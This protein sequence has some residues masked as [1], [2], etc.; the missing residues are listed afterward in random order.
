MW[1]KQTA[2][3]TQQKLAWSAKKDGLDCQEEWPGAPRRMAWSTVQEKLAMTP[4][5]ATVT[6]KILKMAKMLLVV[7]HDNNQPARQQ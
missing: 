2:Q 1:K 6:I 3:M 7:L 4:Q 5:V